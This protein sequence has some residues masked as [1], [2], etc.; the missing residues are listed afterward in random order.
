MGLFD[1]IQCEYPLPDPAVQKEIFQTKRLD[2][3]MDRYTITADGRL[4]LHKTRYE[5]V[6]EEERP[7]YGTPEW[8][9]SP[10]TRFLGS[11]RV[12][13]EGDVEL[14]YHGDI[15]FYTPIGGAGDDE[16]EWFE[17]QARFTEGRLQWIRRV[18]R[19]RA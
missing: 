7:S 4:I 2:C 14:V 8:E 13:P 9:T 12:V 10:F 18:D 16:P 11:L 15:E 3:S 1:E 19:S 17:F 5:L 6:P